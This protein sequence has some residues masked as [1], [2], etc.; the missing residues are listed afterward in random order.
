[1]FN[2]VVPVN[3]I[4]VEMRCVEIDM[5]KICET[6]FSLSFQ[7]DFHCQYLKSSLGYKFY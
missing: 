4:C 5:G 7:R 6:V 3:K 2:H 1:M